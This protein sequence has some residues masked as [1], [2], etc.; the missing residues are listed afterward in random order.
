MKAE[1]LRWT[2]PYPEQKYAALSIGFTL[3]IPLDI[4]RTTCLNIQVLSRLLTECSYVF[5]IVAHRAVA[6][7][8]QRDVRIYR[9]LSGQRLGKHVPGATNQRTIEILLET[10]CFFVV[11]PEELS[12]KQLGRLSEFGMEV[13][14]KKT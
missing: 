3:Y 13:C 14:E 7:R 9:A 6:M 2:T 12:G 11:R 10:V 4:T 1:A 8:R 5:H